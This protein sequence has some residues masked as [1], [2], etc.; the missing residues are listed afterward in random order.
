MTQLILYA[1]V[2][3]TKFGK[4]FYPKDGHPYIP[5]YGPTWV[6]LD[7]P[8]MI[9]WFSKRKLAEEALEKIKVKRTT[10]T[11]EGYIFTVD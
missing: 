2:D 11:I 9:Q 10:T 5:E 8:T 6:K 7:R 1:I 4:F 3:G